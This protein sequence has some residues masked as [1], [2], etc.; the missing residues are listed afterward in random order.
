MATDSNYPADRSGNVGIFSD[1]DAHAIR[2]K[3]RLERDLRLRPEGI[4]QYQ[5]AQGDF[6]R[7]P[8]SDPNFSRPPVVATMDVLVIGGGFGGLLTAVQ[9]HK[10][11]IRNFRIVDKAADFGGTWYW[12]RYPGAACDIE[13]YIYMPLLEEV[14]TIPSRK[15]VGQPELFEHCRAIAKKWDLYSTALLQTKITELRWAE[16]ESR[17]E[18]STNHGDHL[19]ARFVCIS[20]GASHQ[21]KLPR[22]PGI[23]DFIGKAFHTARWDYSYTGESLDRLADKAVGVVGTGASAV[24]CIPWLAKAARQLYVFQRTPSTVD[25]RNQRPTDQ[26]WVASLKPGWHERRMENFDIIVSGGRAEE[27]FVQDGWTEIFRNVER[28]VN[29]GGERAREMADLRNM[30]RIRRRIDEIVDDPATAEKLKPYYN[31][32]CKRPCFHDDYLATFNRPNVTLV[33]THGHG[34][35]RV[36]EKGVVVK[37]RQYDLDCLVFATGF[38]MQ[39]AFAERMGFETYGRDGLSLSEKWKGGMSTLH[40]IHVRDFPNYMI[41]INAQSAVAPNITYVMTKESEHVADIIRRCL[42][43]GVVEIEPSTTAELAWVEEVLSFGEMKRAFNE[44]CTPGY[45]NSEGAQLDLAVRNN[46]YGGG[47]QKY[48]SRLAEWRNDGSM[49]GMELRR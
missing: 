1:I 4:G 22:I 5:T 16:C 13:S 47:S 14:G 18:A 15:Y 24:Q 9:L 39:T 8:F 21:P 17:W 45:V 33:D 29:A 43:E 7:D 36:C 20:P 37:G 46:F 41:L 12:N 35:E 28:A 34:V 32:M 44:E 26:Q 48:L 19:N 25:A 42:D 49:P 38:D 30:A 6:V 11:G 31:Q 23:E 40:G 2:A 3:Y 10:C 27:D